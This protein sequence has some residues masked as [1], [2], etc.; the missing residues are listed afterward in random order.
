M[1]WDFS[2]PTGTSSA[3][4]LAFDLV[5]Y[6]CSLISLYT[7][8]G[9]AIVNVAWGIHL[10]N[11]PLPASNSGVISD[12]ASIWL[13]IYMVLAMHLTYFGW[14]CPS[15][16]SGSS[17]NINFAFLKCFFD[18]LAREFILFIYWARTVSGAQTSLQGISIVMFSTRIILYIQSQTQIGPQSS[19]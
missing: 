19:W 11:D 3:L 14:S 17:P 4:A 10:T 1:G 18:G 5:L 8:N 12:I 6:P 13:S 2:F 15:S 7:D 9:S 16:I